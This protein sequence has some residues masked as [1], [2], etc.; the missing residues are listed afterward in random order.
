M[1]DKNNLDKI[2]IFHHNFVRFCYLAYLAIILQF[3]DVYHLLSHVPQFILN[4]FIAIC[5]STVSLNLN[6]YYSPI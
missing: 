1:V 3:D 6:L 4:L 5:Y 2:E